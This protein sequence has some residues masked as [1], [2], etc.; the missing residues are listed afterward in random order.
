MG[1]QP[2]QILYVRKQRNYEGSGDGEPKILLWFDMESQQYCAT[3]TLEQLFFPNY[4][5]QKS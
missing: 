5:H 4:P 2:D 3:S 1:D